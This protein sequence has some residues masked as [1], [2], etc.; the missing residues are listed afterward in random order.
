MLKIFKLQVMF[1]ISSSSIGE[2]FAMVTNT[3]NKS[4][5]KLTQFFS[6]FN[7]PKLT[8]KAIVND[9]KRNFIFKTIFHYI[10]ST[11]LSL[12]LFPFKFEEK[13]IIF[14]RFFCDKNAFSLI[15]FSTPIFT[16]KKLFIQPFNIVIQTII[17][18]FKSNN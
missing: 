16:E 4:D 5:G 9:N 15:D 2:I 7:I 1:N 6:N 18:S 13:I 11:Q 10:T 3:Q 17:T 12:F 8:F 14:L